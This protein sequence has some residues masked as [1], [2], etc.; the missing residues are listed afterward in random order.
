MTEILRQIADATDEWPRRVG[1]M[2]FAHDSEKIDWLLKPAALTGWLGTRCGVPPR[3]KKSDGLHTQSEVF[4][5]LKRT[6]EAYEDVELFPHFPPIENV[7]YACGPIIPG[8][9]SKLRELVDRFNPE[10]DID[11]DLILALFV[12]PGWGASGSRPAFC[13]T[14][15]D[16]RGSGKTTLAKMAGLLWG[17]RIEISPDESIEQVKQRLLSPDAMTKR[18]VNVDNVKSMR[19]S[20]AGIE[21]LITTDI[22]SGKRMYHGEGQRPNSLTWITTL[23]GVSFATD[24]AQRSII[25][26]IKRPNYSGNWQDET[27]EF[28][29]TNRAAIIAD[30]IGFLREPS[31][32]QLASFTRWGNWERDILSRLP[33]PGEAQRVICERQG[34]ADAEG[35][36]SD[37]IEDGIR[38]RL[39]QAHYAP[40]TAVVFLS[41]KIVAAVLTECTG[42]RYGTSK[43]TRAI[44][45][46]IR[47]KKLRNIAEAGRTYG[48]GFIWQG[49]QSE[50]GEQISTDLESRLNQWDA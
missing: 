23:N 50:P 10:T 1:N 5:E 3:F 22:I 49:P 37:D 21:A 33:E 47:E 6:A 28:I 18:V 11:R 29:E 34:E 38:E 12:T 32:Y 42:D 4:E 36:E 41:N 39:I 24:M 19:F 43:A 17:G 26:K 2:L 7:Y 15:D 27:E 16:G 48:R 14:S 8:D 13:L 25:I 45:Q 40:E 30:V 35:S 20:N 31:D 44:N 9:G 46:R